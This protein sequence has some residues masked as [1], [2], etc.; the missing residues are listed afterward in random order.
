MANRVVAGL[1]SAGLWS[2]RVDKHGLVSLVRELANFRHSNIEPPGG[3][4]AEFEPLNTECVDRSLRL[5][6]HPDRIEQSLQSQRGGE[7]ER[8]RILNFMLEKI[9]RNRMP[10]GRWGTISATSRTRCA[11]FPARL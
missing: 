9:R 1:V 2:R 7:R 3:D 6:L 11:P 10:C 8:T 4:V 5:M